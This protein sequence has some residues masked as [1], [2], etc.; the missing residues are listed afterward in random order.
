IEDGF[1]IGS[2]GVYHENF[3]SLSPAAADD[4]LRRSRDWIEEAC[5]KA[6]QHFAFPK[7]QRGK[8]IT[9]ETLALALKYYRCVFSAYGAH[10]FPE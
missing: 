5:G 3:G 1:T 9:E 10:C 2:H 7:G 8:N 6:P 4:I